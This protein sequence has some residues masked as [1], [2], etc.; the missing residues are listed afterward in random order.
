MYFIF[1][2]SIRL[3]IL[4]LLGSS[5]SNPQAWDMIKAFELKGGERS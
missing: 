3:L 4:K 5:K 2:D 1:L